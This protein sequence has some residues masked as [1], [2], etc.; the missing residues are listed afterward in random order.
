M[1][2]SPRWVMLAVRDRASGGDGTAVE[3]VP[4]ELV[5]RVSIRTRQVDRASIGF[6]QARSPEVIAPETL[7]R[8]AMSPQRV[9]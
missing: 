4:Y 7:L 8:A 5:R 1:G 9:R 6:N 2:V 3:L